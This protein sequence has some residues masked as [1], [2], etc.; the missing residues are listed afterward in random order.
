M[1]NFSEMDNG[2]AVTIILLDLTPK[3]NLVFEVEQKSQYEMLHL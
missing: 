2:K 1:Q 3:L